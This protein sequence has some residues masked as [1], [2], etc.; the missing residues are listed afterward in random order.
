MSLDLSQ[1]AASKVKK[2]FIERGS[3]IRLAAALAVAVQAYSGLL[4]AAPYS[5][6][7]V[8]SVMSQ[9]EKKIQELR[10]Q[11]VNQLRI[12]LGRRLPSARRADLYLRL[13]ELY[14]EAYRFEFLFEGRAHERRLESDKPDKFI[15]RA[16]SRPHLQ[17]AIR[18]CKDIVAFNI[19]YSK[20][21]QVYYF[22]GY[23]YGELGEVKESVRYFKE[24]I[25][26]F[27][28]GSFAG[29]AYRELGEYAFE[30]R[31]Y[32]DARLYLEV[33]A[34]R[35][36]PRSLSRIQHKLAWSYYRTRDYNRAVDMMKQA[37]TS[38][39][40]GQEKL[41]S[42]REEALRDLAIFMTETGRVE[43]ALDYFQKSVGE[44]N[45]YPRILESLGKQYER[46]VEPIKATQ[47]YESLLKTH[48][49]EEAA[50][51]VR[52]KL[53]DLDLRRG[54]TTDALGRVQNAKI[55]HGSS[56][57]DETRASAK[58]LRS[59]LRRTATENHGDFRKKGSRASLVVAEDF[60]SAYLNLFLSKEDPLRETPEIQMYL[61][62]VKRELGKSSEASK[63][64]RG[65]VESQDKRYAKEAGALWTASLADSIRKDTARGQA[66]ASGKKSAPTALEQEF[67]G[68]ADDLEKALEDTQEG[69]EA[70]LRAAQV[71][72]GYGDSQKDAK[73][74]VRRLMEKY[75]KSPQA[76]TAARLY[77]QMAA[78]QYTAAEKAQK[79]DDLSDAADD[80]KDT[81]EELRENAALMASDQQSGAKLAAAVLEQ[82]TRIKIGEI[83]VREKRKDFKG[84]A[85][86]YEALAQG[87]KNR[88]L[89]EKSYENTVAS[90]LKSRDFE[91]AK[92]VADLWLK[93][94]SD[95]KPAVE[96]FRTLAT[97]LLIQ[98]RA[99]EAAQVFEGLGAAGKDADSLE[100]SGRIYEAIGQPALAQKSRSA[101]FQ[102]Y[103]KAAGRARVALA[104]A[105]LFEASI[106]EGEAAKAYLAC[107]ASPEFEAEC[108]ARLA[109]LY[110]RAQDKG[111]AQSLFKKVSVLSG[112]G[113]S[114]FV[115]YSR[116]KLAEL[117]D[118]EFKPMAL[119]LPEATLKKGIQKR[120]EQIES[121]GR[122]YG[123]AVEAGGPFAISALDRLAR[124][125]KLFADDVD[126][127][128]VPAGASPETI[129]K[130]R[131]NLKAVSDPLRAK[132][133]S[134]WK[135]AHL[136]AQE[137]EILSPALIDISE[138]L[139]E[140]GT[141]RLSR[142]QGARGKLRLAGIAADGGSDGRSSALSKVREKLSKNA[143]DAMAWVD[144]GNLLWGEGKPALA[145]IA[146]DRA[147]ALDAKGAAGVAALNNRAVIVLSGDGEEDWLK[148]AE[149]SALL[150]DALSVDPLSVAAK[151]NRAAVF[152]YYRIFSKAKPLWEQVIAK[153]AS[154]DAHDGLAISLQGSGDTS[155]AQASFTRATDSGASR[156]RFALVYHETAAEFVAGGAEKC[157]ER[158]SDLA[159]MDDEL[160][161]FEKQSAETLKSLCSVGRKA[162]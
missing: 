5:D 46:N 22:L 105:R 162:K 147:L 58:S 54:R 16:R 151:M 98:G 28:E 108:G 92:R 132:A 139:M 120:L 131:K 124:A 94:F 47:V 137:Q 97:A 82:E 61:A 122:A 60:Y 141:D 110:L 125:A 99:Q 19:P 136:K 159:D 154:A 116:F 66:D 106:Q 50:F 104:S 15:D 7:E 67:V 73:K 86:G 128:A 17:S 134:T 101:Y 114:P 3:R 25:K 79:D 89:A 95:S 153:A 91:N 10:N 119:E 90:D 56:G 112:K 53:V 31:G 52:V 69:R 152:N 100:F 109:D 57:E 24:L 70:A 158:A 127:I 78:D 1:N 129:D 142:A 148:A 74:R 102:T 12:A 6:S 150:R 34:K 138:R 38:A 133:L 107:I 4:W 39:A 84:A 62:D 35:A 33:A 126:A 155:G 121:L 11:E 93:R 88:A 149:G 30:T 64:Y 135:Q 115:G 8:A 81:V 76:L 143:R 29:E 157:S 130:F 65:V 55:F 63:L 118:A 20:L 44:R 117:T 123:A 111:Q 36:Q 59:M 21:D 146:Y 32:S 14:I 43:E 37:V 72:A 23:N 68:A 26:R 40:S 96:S 160:K 156:S 48:P 9:D 140:S 145:A 13:A 113:G 42:V 71:L 2:V 49:D 18:A 41:V 75:S 77:L 45:F 87:T 103:P 144:Y 85:R 27:P 83:A 80:L 161:G 51:R